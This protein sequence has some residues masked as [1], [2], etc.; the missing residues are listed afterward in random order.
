MH[1]ISVDLDGVDL[2]PVD[3]VDPLVGGL[4]LVEKGS[5]M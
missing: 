2:V 5:P 3:R 4:L 1:M